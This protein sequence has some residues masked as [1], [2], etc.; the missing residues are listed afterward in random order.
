MPVLVAG[1]RRNVSFA[2]DRMLC[3]LWSSDIVSVALE[4]CGLSSRQAEVPRRDF[5]ICP[6]CVDRC[7][8]SIFVG[9][10]TYQERHSLNCF[11][12]YLLDRLQTRQARLRMLLVQIWGAC[13]LY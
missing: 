10:D 13:K 8:L 4:V 3:L 12:I 9:V 6:R 11:A 1:G 2:P 5:D 7:R